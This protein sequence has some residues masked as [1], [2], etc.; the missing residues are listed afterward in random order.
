ALLNRMARVMDE[1]GQFQSPVLIIQGDADKIVQPVVSRKFFDRLEVGDKTW[2]SYPGMY[3]ELL[4]D[5]GREEVVNDILHWLETR[6]RR[7][8]QG[9][10]S[11]ERKVLILPFAK[12]F[13]Q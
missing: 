10:S 5:F 3:H 12:F 11:K 7:I 1:A 9:R 8:I 4:N 2:K 6:M 13:R